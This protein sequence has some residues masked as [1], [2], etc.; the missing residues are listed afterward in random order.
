MTGIPAV[1]FFCL[2]LVAV[3]ATFYQFRR[4]ASRKHHFE[5]QAH[6]RRLIIQFVGVVIYILINITSN[7]LGVHNTTETND[8][9]NH[10]LW[11]LLP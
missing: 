2:Q 5:Y 9:V 6:E 3:V 4:I 1:A 7:F 8:N 11:Y 10:F